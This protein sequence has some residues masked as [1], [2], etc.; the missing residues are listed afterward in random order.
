MWK[1]VLI[2]KELSPE[3]FRYQTEN[4]NLYEMI[5]KI[6][7]AICSDNTIPRDYEGSSWKRI[8]FLR[9]FKSYRTGG[10]SG[11]GQFVFRAMLDEK[12]NPACYST[13]AIIKELL[14]IQIKRMPGD[15]YA[16]VM[17]ISARDE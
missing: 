12:S 10:R 9:Y 5:D 4:I 14:R 7:E 15:I 17:N 11:V 16:L 1:R 6:G 8:C 2:R 3:Q 13:V